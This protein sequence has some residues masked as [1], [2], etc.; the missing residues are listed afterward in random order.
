MPAAL[1][2]FVND[3]VADKR[4]LCSLLDEQTAITKALAPLV[5]YPARAARLRARSARQQ[6]RRR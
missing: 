5:R 1:L 2:A 3:W 6:P 4:H